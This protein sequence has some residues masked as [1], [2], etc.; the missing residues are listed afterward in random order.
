MRS[1]PAKLKGMR[2]V[3]L[4][5]IVFSAC[6][7][8]G[9]GERDDVFERVEDRLAE[10]PE[11]QVGD[12]ANGNGSDAPGGQTNDNSGPGPNGDEMAGPNAWSANALAAESGVSQ[13]TFSRWLRQAKLVPMTD[14]RALAGRRHR[15]ER[16]VLRQEPEAN[17]AR[18]R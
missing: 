7:R 8:A 14:G 10:D 3:A 11:T 16:R 18:A 9:F 12:N 5:L 2:R 1:G 4:L 15:I 13:N 6:G 17:R